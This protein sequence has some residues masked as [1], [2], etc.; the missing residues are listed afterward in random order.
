M[1]IVF[2]MCHGSRHKENCNISKI[3]ENITFLSLVDPDSGIIHNCDQQFLVSKYNFVKIIIIVAINCTIH[4]N[5]I[6]VVIRCQPFSQLNYYI[7]CKDAYHNYY[8]CLFA[9]YVCFHIRVPM[10]NR[11][12]RKYVVGFLIFFQTVLCRLCFCLC[13]V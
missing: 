4:P 1:F 3:A 13:I 9:A 11:S 8:F 10:V 7:N 12:A 6:E 5:C 2:S